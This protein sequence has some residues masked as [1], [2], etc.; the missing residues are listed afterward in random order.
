[1]S[2]RGDFEFRKLKFKMPGDQKLYKGERQQGRWTNEEHE[3]FLQSFAKYRMINSSNIPEIMKTT[4]WKAIAEAVG[5]R[6]VP[7]TRQHAQKHFRSIWKKRKVR[8]NYKGKIGVLI[9]LPVEAKIKC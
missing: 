1:M 9:Y 8:L 2:P 7:Q 3:A 4:N 6:N 5:T